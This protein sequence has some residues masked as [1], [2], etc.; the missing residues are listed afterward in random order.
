MQAAIGLERPA[1]CSARWLIA[2]FVSLVGVLGG[3]AHE[4]VSVPDVAAAVQAAPLDLTGFV[5][6]RA[7]FREIYCAVAND[8][9]TKLPEHR[10]CELALVRLAGEALPGGRPVDLHSRRAP[11]LTVLVPGLLGECLRADLDPFADAL[12]HV[13]RLGYPIRVLRVAGRSS[14]A[15]NAKQLHEELQALPVAEFP[16]LV[17]IGHSKG[18]VDILEMLVRYPDLRARVVAV[19]SVASPILGSPLADRADSWYA[20]LVESFPSSACPKGD[21][22]GIKSLATTERQHWVE[23]NRLPAEVRYFSLGAV[24]LDDDVST[25][26]KPFYSE[27][28]TYDRRNDG[29]VLYRDAVIPAGMLLGFV[30]AD[31]FAV[32]IPFSRQRPMLSATLIDRNAFPREVLLESILRFVDEELSSR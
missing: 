28:S 12:A 21:Q 23:A 25:L 5:D 13:D 14:S 1:S 16:H 30:R 4:T 18:A 10:P 6:A 9:G 31:H 19:V 17:L 22:G 11:F 24:A 29:Q 8:H 32:A 15:A 20:K 27:L 2:L 7:R 3:C 26:L